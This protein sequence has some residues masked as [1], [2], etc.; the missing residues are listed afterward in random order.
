MLLSEGHAD[1][2]R[3]PLAVLWSE[4]RIVRQRHN[5]RAVQDAAVMEAVIGAVISRRKGQT[6]LNT[7]LKRILNSD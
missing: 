6:T 1:A 7:L 2:R 4:A 3:Y 5:A